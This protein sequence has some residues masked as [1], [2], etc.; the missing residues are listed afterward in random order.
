MHVELKKMKSISDDFIN[1]SDR[2]LYDIERIGTIITSLSV[3]SDMETTVMNLKGI[4]D[5]L[6]QNRT[7][8]MKAGYALEDIHKLYTNAE[9][10]CE[11]RAETGSYSYKR[12]EAV[13]TGVWTISEMPVYEDVQDVLK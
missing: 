4:Q 8:L 6:E 2:M 13:D 12:S 3:M 5:A 9:N 10:T 11:E 7:R 1:Q